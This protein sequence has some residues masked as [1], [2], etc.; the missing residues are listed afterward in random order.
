MSRSETIREALLALLKP[1][2]TPLTA[3]ELRVRLRVRALRLAE[4]EVLHALRCL[5]AEGLVR[6]ER[7]RW[8]A[9][10]PFV[11][12]SVPVPAAH[13]PAEQHG[14]HIYNSPISS[15]LS[16]AAP[17]VWSPSKSRVLNNVPAAGE[18]ASPAAEPV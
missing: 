15:V 10:V 4:Y 5:R 1:A 2:S 3:A 12:A 18:P 13:Q 7:G 16:P 14:L 8:S 11:N 17:T 6:L 9:T